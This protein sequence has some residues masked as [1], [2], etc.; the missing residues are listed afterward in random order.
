MALGENNL[1]FH[2]TQITDRKFRI[3]NTEMNLR[4]KSEPTFFMQQAL[5]VFCISLKKNWRPY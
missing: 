3:E 1:A 5:Y 2:H 4:V